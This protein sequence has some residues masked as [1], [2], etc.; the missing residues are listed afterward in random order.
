MNLIDFFLPWALS[1]SLLTVRLAVAL[2]LSPAL[3]AFRVPGMAKVVLVVGLSMLA[4]AQR[5]PV[6]AAL[7]MA[8]EPWHALGAVA[9]EVLIGAMLGLGVH[10]VLAALGLAG[11]LMDV[12]IG[13]GIASMFDPV[14]RSGSNVMGMLTGLLGVTLFF[15]ADAHLVLARTLATSVELFPLGQA[16]ALDDPM[17][18]LY[19]TGAVYSLGL[20]FA[21]PVAMALFLTDLVV[22]VVSRNMPQLNVLVLSIPV[23][24]MVGYAVLALSVRAWGG[25]FQ[26]GLG[27]MAQ[28]LGA[29]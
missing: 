20:A 26:D 18:L 25:L 19:A 28:A 12:Q 17:Q 7:Q 15:A 21:A 24:V 6:D 13:F 11:R 16:P 4:M 3:M 5:E 9:C 1:V 8:A 10:V 23:K 22:G 29:H 14:T 2:A 27:R